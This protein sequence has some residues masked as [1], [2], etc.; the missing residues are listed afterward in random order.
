MRLCD[1]LLTHTARALRAGRSS[2]R[3]LK[4]K[5]TTDLRANIY[6]ALC[7]YNEVLFYRLLA[8]SYR[9]MTAEGLH[10][11]SPM[12]CQ[13]FSHI[14]RGPGD[15]SSLTAARTLVPRSCGTVPIRIRR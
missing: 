6:Y 4:K 7:G 12:A 2:L 11:W 15:D 14:Y 1:G 9:R 8:R 5:G 13:Q 3:G 10:R